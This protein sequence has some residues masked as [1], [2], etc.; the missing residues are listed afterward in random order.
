MN[1]AF[2]S[3]FPSDGWACYDVLVLRVHK[4]FTTNYWV[5]YSTIESSCAS[6]GLL[7]LAVAIDGA[8][9]YFSSRP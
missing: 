6:G 7:V 4:K 5:P 8:L 2:L 1:P 9:Y 3:F